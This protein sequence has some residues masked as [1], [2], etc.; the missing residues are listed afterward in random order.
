ML[1]ESGTYPFETKLLGSFNVYN[2][3]AAIALG[4]EFGITI[5]ELQSAVRRVKS[6]EHR[7]ELK[8]LGDMYQID[9]AYNSNPVGAKMALDVLKMMPGTRVVVTPGMTELGSKEFEYN[10][11]FGTQMKDACDYVILV[12]K[13]QTEAIYQGLQEVGFPMDH[14][15]VIQ[16]VR[17]SYA[18]VLAKKSSKKD[19]YAL[20][21]ND[22]PD[23]LITKE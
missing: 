7:L 1:L 20:Y 4:L 13:K 11:L 16:D 3:L 18:M 14:V 22:L 12:G 2:I 8:R 21:E 9:D 6:V 23:A 15:E 10:R 19:I 5:P 17:D